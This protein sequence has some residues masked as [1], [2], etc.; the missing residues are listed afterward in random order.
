MSNNLPSELLS[1]S[2]LFTLFEALK[3]GLSAAPTQLSFLKAAEL[4]QSSEE[5]KSAVVIRNVQIDSDATNDSSIVKTLATECQITGVSSV[6]R[7]KTAGNGPPL[8]KIQFQQKDDALALLSKFEQVKNKVKELQHASARPDLSRPELIKFRESWRKA[9]ALN[10]QSG[11][12][13]SIR[14]DLICLTE[15]KIDDSFPSS[16]LSLDGMFSVVRKDR[17][18]HGGGIAIL[19]SKYIKFQIIDL[20]AEFSSVEVLG[21]DMSI[22][23][24]NIRLVTVYHPHHSKDLN[25]LIASLEYLLRS[26]KHCVITGDFNLPHVN[27]RDF[28]AHD[29]YCKSFLNFVK[30]NGLHQCV[31]QPTRLNNILDLVLCNTNLVSDAQVRDPF[32]DHCLVEIELKVPKAISKNFKT[33][34]LFHKADYSFINYVLSNINWFAKLSQLTV[35]AMYET[36]MIT[37]T[38]LIERFV[39][40]RRLNTSVKKHSLEIRKL[41]TE[42]LKTWR[43]E[44]N[45]VTYKKISGVLK[46]KLFEEEQKQTENSL[47]RCSS[48]DFFKFINSRIKED[49]SIL[50]LKNKDGDCIYDNAAK[51]DIFSEFFSEVFTEDDG[52][53]PHCP[54]RTLD[55]PLS[56]T[57]FPHVIEC[58]LFKLKARVNTTPDGIPAIFLKRT[59]TSLALPLSIIFEK[60]FRTSCL[61]S[62]WKTAIVLP[63]HK[64][65]SRSTP[66]NYRPISLTSSVCKVM[67]KLVR[68][69]LCNFLESKRLLST[70][71]YGFRSNLGT[72]SQLLNYQSTLIQN[73]VGKQNTHCVYIDFRKAF[74]KVSI[75][76][77]VTKLASFGLNGYLLGWLS[78]FLSNRDQKI[79]VNGSLS[80]PKPVKS[81]V[82]QGSVLG[83]LLFLLFVN[84][85]GDTFE[86][87]FLL[88]A[89]DLK[90][91]DVDENK[92]QRD[93]Q[94]LESWCGIW[95]LD[96]APDKCESI[97]FLYSRKSPPSL[98]IFSINA[99]T[100]PRTNVIRDLGVWISSDLSFLQ[101]HAIMIKKVHQRINLLF[102]VLRRATL[103]VFIKCYVIYIRP[104][105]EYGTLITSPVAKSNIIVLVK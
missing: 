69:H 79:I 76:K 17:N 104:L 23:G 70:C 85:I 90:L 60:S 1:N 36:F 39:P 41:M 38:D 84:D 47:V 93:L 32:S 86:S 94:R 91:F 29:S 88:F 25:P 19:I 57:F 89:D 97:S 74:D 92:I 105:L 9:I 53:T 58:V 8:L 51:A 63:L 83:P 75:P 3:K 34:K 54:L 44:G 45:S 68:S 82:P 81:G 6:F 42:K 16:L 2:A 72:E 24:N 4:A 48:K 103:E 102:N 26:T 35:E 99:T 61:P 65:G 87:K 100:I 15:T 64:K 30:N 22:K 46:Q 10:D 66:N 80:L 37:L 71:Q 40:T 55:S 20:P 27:W 77:L 28:S 78:D 18:K 62:I 43:R 5:R 67:E 101:H 96:I 98:P 50:S 11:K 52:F 7:L 21:V 31:F 12:K 73:Q 13:E 33:V 56:M 49:N 59:C 95:Q 14:F